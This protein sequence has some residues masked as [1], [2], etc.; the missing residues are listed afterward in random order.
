ML[1]DAIEG[2]RDRALITIPFVQVARQVLTEQV[3]STISKLVNNLAK[4][5]PTFLLTNPAAV[6]HLN[7][8]LRALFLVNTPGPVHLT[9]QLL[10]ALHVLRGRVEAAYTSIKKG[11]SAFHFICR[12]IHH[13][14][15][16]SYHLS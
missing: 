7:G 13:Y 9:P 16:I 1:I 14:P 11:Q 2:D 10:Q 4:V 15:V 8:D 6:N 3:Q 12:V 5:A